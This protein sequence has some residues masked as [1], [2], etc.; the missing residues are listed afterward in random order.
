MRSTPGSLPRC[1]VDWS[2]ALL[3]RGAFWAAVVFPALYPPVVLAGEWL[4]TAD[5]LLF[6]L[7]AV[8]ALLLLVGRQHITTERETTTSKQGQRAL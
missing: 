5:A 8:H 6:G 3:S 2:R 1:T 7:T 4:P